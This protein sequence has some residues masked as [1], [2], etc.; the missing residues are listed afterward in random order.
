MLLG[1]ASLNLA[2]SAWGARERGR[3]FDRLQDAIERHSIVIEIRSEIDDQYKR[4]KVASDLVGIEAAPL[5][6]TESVRV[7]S[8]ISDISLKLSQVR[9]DIGQSD[10]L[11]RRIV[12][13][14]DSLLDSWH[15]YY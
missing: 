7:R 5:R 13:T 3:A 9:L 10:T 15:T 8:T 1:V 11:L 6:L 12:T 4:V 14:T 2:A